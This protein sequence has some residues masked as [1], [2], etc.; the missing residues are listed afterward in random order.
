MNDLIRGSEQGKP[1]AV[2]IDFRG[3]RVCAEIFE[4]EG[5]IGFVDIGWND[6]YGCSGHPY[7]VVYGQLEKINGRWFIEDET[8]EFSFFLIKPGKP[9]M[10]Q[11]KAW[12]IAKHEQGRPYSRDDAKVGIDDLAQGPN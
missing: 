10:E 2:D 4:I 6:K 7:H 9:E 1:I 12:E 8:H 5:G 3:K 11:W